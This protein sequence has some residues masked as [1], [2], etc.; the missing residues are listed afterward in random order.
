MKNYSIIL[1]ICAGLFTSCGGKKLE[2]QVSDL[3][4][5]NQELIVKAEQQ[6]ESISEFIASLS[7]IESNLAQI[8]EREM[9]IEL[10]NNETKV[11]GDVKERIKEN[12]KVINELMSQNKKTIDDL[13]TRIA[14]SS[15]QNSKLKRSL[16]KLKAELAQQVEEKGKQITLLKEDLEKMDFTVQELNA[17][18]DT[19]H[20]ANQQKD[21]LINKQVHQINTAYFGAA[22]P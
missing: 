6:E 8:R 22:C 2:K 4:N 7:D 14:N 15:G 21:E 18:L 13:T 20:L 3:Q 16:E 12:I 1:L 19:L 11:T 9:N 17:S 5:E 10:E